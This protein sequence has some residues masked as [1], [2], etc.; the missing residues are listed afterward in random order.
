MTLGFIP[1]LEIGGTH[2]T[3]AWVEQDTWQAVTD[4]MTHLPLPAHGSRQELVSCFTEAARRLG[5][6]PGTEWAVAIPGPFDYG[7]GIGLF[8]HVGKFDSLYGVD[9][10]QELMTQILPVPAFIHFLNDADAFG[11]GEYAAGAAKGHERAVCITLGTGVGS[12]FLDSGEPRKTGPGLPPNGEA[13]RLNFRGRPLEDTISRRAIRQA[14]ARSTGMI[15]DPVPDVREIAERSR[16]GDE[17]A[18]LVLRNAF[19]CLGVAL[20][21]AVSGFDASVLV[22]GGSIARSWDIVEPAVR[23]GLMQAVPA[24]AELDV[25]PAGRPADAALLGAAYWAAHHARR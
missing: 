21:T 7:L 20:S 11:I 6:R 15:P 10:R 18:K 16:A 25:R 19:E 23:Q 3:A 14:Y 8:E 4:S 22:V 5:S 2:V 9:V 1:V 12:V 17:N 13:Y 24:L